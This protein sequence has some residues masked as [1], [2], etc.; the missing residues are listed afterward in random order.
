MLL[1]IDAKL[2]GNVSRF[3]NS[4]CDPNIDSKV[5]FDPQTQ[6]PHLIFYSNRK[7]EPGEELTVFYGEE[8]WKAKEDLKCFCQ[9][10]DCFFK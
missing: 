8:W 10:N 7:I 6:T 2:K 1:I 3:I 4:S 9:S 5:V